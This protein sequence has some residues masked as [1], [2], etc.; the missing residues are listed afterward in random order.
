MRYSPLVSS[1]I[2]IIG[3]VAIQKP[4]AYPQS[5]I[6]LFI[7]LPDLDWK[8]SKTCSLALKPHT[9]T[10]KSLL[11]RWNRGG[12]CVH[13]TGLFVKDDKI[14]Y[15]QNRYFHLHHYKRVMT[16]V[17]ILSSINYYV[18]PVTWLSKWLNRAQGDPGHDYLESIM[19]LILL[20]D[21]IRTPFQL[22]NR[23]ATLLNRPDLL[24]WQTGNEIRYKM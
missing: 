15:S 24:Q 23:L 1:T 6:P 5:R 10:M 4:T 19:K 21:R 2:E 13:T 12:M 14:Y 3:Y 22:D 8:I 17:L 18:V 9:S 16:K 20:S 7:K 11:G